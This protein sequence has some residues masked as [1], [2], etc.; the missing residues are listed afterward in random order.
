MTAVFL[1]AEAGEGTRAVGAERPDRPDGTTV[2]KKKD[3]S[4]TDDVVGRSV[5]ASP[6]SRATL[7]EK[8]EERA[9]R[10][11]P[12]QN[13]PRSLLNQ[14]YRHDAKGHLTGS[15]CA[16]RISQ[17]DRAPSGRSGRQS[18]VRSRVNTMMRSPVRVL[19]SVCRLT[20]STPSRS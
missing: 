20:H 4:A 9:G 15:Q 7:T 10:R 6:L 1:M 18:G 5:C 17:P 3:R 16:L 12:S 2:C 13:I 11:F 14:F 19:M 8:N